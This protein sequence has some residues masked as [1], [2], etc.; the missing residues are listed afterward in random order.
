MTSDLLIF[1][2]DGTIIDSKRDLADSVNAMLT[3]MGRA[4]LSDELVFSYVGNGAP[5]LVR[6]ALG[7]DA[8]DADAAIPGARVM[9]LL[10]SQCR[11]TAP[12]RS[13]PA[14]SFRVRL[15]PRTPSRRSSRPASAT[16]WRAC[17]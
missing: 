16:C 12:G 13:W 3:W 15:E 11:R 5:V 1:D 9:L 14:A 10:G 8:S 2:L 17:L 4:P 7:I 6:R